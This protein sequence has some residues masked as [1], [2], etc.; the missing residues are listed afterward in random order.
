[1]SQ[2]YFYEKIGS[3]LQQ[4][5]LNFVRVKSVLAGSSSVL[6]MIRVG[7]YWGQSLLS[8]GNLG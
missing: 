8:L 7:Y 5:D 6:S 2:S 3:G 1:M 4:F